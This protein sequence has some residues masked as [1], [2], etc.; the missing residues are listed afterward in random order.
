MF[1][2]EDLH[3]EKGKYRHI[4]VPEDTKS[5]KVKFKDGDEED[6]K[7]KKKNPLSFRTYRDS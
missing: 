3:P 6:P 7:P 2:S 1:K 4:L 5:V